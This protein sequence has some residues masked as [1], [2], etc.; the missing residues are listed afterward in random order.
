MKKL[1]TGETT[2]QK[3]AGLYRKGILALCIMLGIGILASIA[4][5]G[6]HIGQFSEKE[7]NVISLIPL[8]NAKL[9]DGGS[10]TLSAP[11]EKKPNQGAAVNSKATSSKD[12]SPN[13]GHTKEESKPVYGDLQI[14]DD[15]QTWNTETH[16][17]L[18]KESYNDTVKS[19][20]G[21]KVIAPGTT[22][23]Y[24]FSIKNN[25]NI[26]MQYAISLKVA[27]HLGED[28]T[29]SE[30]P[31]EWRL[32]SDDG[33]IVTD[34]KGYNERTE[35]LQ[36]DY[37]SV[38]NQDQYTIEWRWAFERGG[39]MDEADTDMGNIAAGQDLGVDAAIYVY[40]E[41]RGDVGVDIPLPKTGDP[42][43]IAPY[44]ALAALA[45]LGLGI[46]VF[47]RSR[48]KKDKD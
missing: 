28:Q 38:R 14:V 36:R 41:Q 8:G 10:N 13:T 2:R 19:A 24:H 32:L 17:D 7:T 48:G 29:Y 45:V 44:A 31:L 46:L 40:A 6:G 26:P 47:V 25:G 4:L 30:L 5:L 34:W 39:D 22:H 18:F 27:T 21:E 37:L 9:E 16:I 20:N 43:R 15:V 35:T 33:A 23:S 12:S 42:A 3:K 11:S 1:Q